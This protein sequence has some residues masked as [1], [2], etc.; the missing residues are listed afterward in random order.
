MS[1]KSERRIRKTI[2][3]NKRHMMNDAMREM[4]TADFV[5]RLKFCWLVIKGAK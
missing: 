2:R 1:A 4:M 5:T 3:K